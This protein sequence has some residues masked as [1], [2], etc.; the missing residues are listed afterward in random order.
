M[1]IRD[2]VYGDAD[3]SSNSDIFLVTK[4]GSRNDTTTFFKSKEN[5]IWVNC[6]CFSGNIDQ[7]A[8][9]VTETHGD[10]EHG[11][12]YRL[13]CLLYTSRCV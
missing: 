4:I 13:A 8:T 1:C 9:K 2:R 7:F 3:I 12:A 6:G 11:Q 5:E 10:N